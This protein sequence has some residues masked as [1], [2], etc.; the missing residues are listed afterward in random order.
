MK[1]ESLTDLLLLHAG[2]GSGASIFAFLC[3]LLFTSGSGA[4]ETLTNL[5]QLLLTWWLFLF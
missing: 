5:L 4:G 2:T 1:S 3:S